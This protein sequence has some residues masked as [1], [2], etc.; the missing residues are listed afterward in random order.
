MWFFLN[1]YKK[2]HEKISWI[3]NTGTNQKSKNPDFN[4]IASHGYG[5]GNMYLHKGVATYLVDIVIFQA[6]I[7]FHAIK[8]LVFLITRY[9]TAQGYTIF[10]EG[11]K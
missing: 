4:T 3:Y 7:F 1:I 5:H 11:L 6:C 8:Q 9:I 2:N 10:P